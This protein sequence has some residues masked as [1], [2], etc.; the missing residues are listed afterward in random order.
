[1]IRPLPSPFNDLAQLLARVVL[2]T[3]LIAHG[4]QKLVTNGIGQTAASFEKMGAP[5]PP[6][7]ATFT[8]V[9]EMFGGA[10]LLLGAATTL[11]ALLVVLIMLGAAVLVH[12]GNG[13]FVSDG[14]W[15]LVGV[16]AAAAL[17]LAATGAGRYSVDYA[18]RARRAH[19]AA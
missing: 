16:I 10:L 3:V 18:L 9:V 4:W 19:S 15:E 6:V 13:V 1:M 14:G 5:L 8:A 7:S 11:V 2:A 12:I 17:L